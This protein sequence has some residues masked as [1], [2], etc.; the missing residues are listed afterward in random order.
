M[1][2]EN[3]SLALRLAVLTLLILW[4]GLVAA[5]GKTITVDPGATTIARSRGRST[6]PRPVM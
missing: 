3:G 2:R 1:K 5:E 6:R 4:V